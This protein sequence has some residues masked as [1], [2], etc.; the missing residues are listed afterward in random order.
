MLEL[1]SQPI[2]HPNDA[3]YAVIAR[4]FERLLRDQ[5]WS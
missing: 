4:A 2:I 1:A 5:R 3:G